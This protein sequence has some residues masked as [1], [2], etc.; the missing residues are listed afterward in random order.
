MR[1][2]PSRSSKATVCAKGTCVTVFGPAAQFITLVVVLTTVF[3][4]GALIAKAIK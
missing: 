1:K 2:L 4:A 3:V